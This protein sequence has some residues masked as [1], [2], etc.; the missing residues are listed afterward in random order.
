MPLICHCE[1]SEQSAGLPNASN[2]ARDKRTHL[3]NLTAEILDLAALPR[4]FRVIVR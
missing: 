3:P 2:P 4:H 1:R